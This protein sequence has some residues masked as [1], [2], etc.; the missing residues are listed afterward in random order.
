MFSLTN[1]TKHLPVDPHKNEQVNFKTDRIF[2]F[3]KTIWI[4]NDCNKHENSGSSFRGNYHPPAGITNN[5]E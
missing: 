2:G 1:G 3:Y 5:S 4:M